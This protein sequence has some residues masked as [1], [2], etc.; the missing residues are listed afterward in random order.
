MIYVVPVLFIIIFVYCIIKNIPAYDFFVKGCS[1][2][3]GLVISIFPYLC[4]IFI[5]VT[6]MDVSGIS[7]KLCI[8]CEPLLTSV[9]IPS[10]LSKLIILRPFSG[11]GSLAIVK[12]IFL[13]YGADSYIGRCASVVVGASDTIFYVTAIYFSTVKV[14]KL[15]YTIPICIIASFCGSISACFFVRLLGGF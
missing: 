4:A 7:D 2:A 10:E 9:G 13:R 6:L 12:D 11:N 14:K 5:F 1:E 3:I 8:I 15:R